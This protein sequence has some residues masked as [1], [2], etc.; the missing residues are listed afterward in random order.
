MLKEN[1]KILI[2]KEG[3]GKAEY[4]SIHNLVK[5]YF[6]MYI[7]DGINGFDCIQYRGCQLTIHDRDGFKD[8]IEIEEDLLD[9]LEE[10]LLLKNKIDLSIRIENMYNTLK[11]ELLDKNISKEEKEQK[12]ENGKLELKTLFELNKQ[13]LDKR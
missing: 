7:V 13:Q 8:A 12:L 9:K 1:I 3:F 5:E 2:N 4:D 10:L 6:V 11:K